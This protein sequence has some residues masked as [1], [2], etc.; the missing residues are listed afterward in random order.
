MEKLLRRKTSISIREII[1]LLL[2]L[3]ALIS[4]FVCFIGNQDYYELLPLLPFTFII[5]QLFFGVPSKQFFTTKIINL[6]AYLRYVVLP[7]VYS[8]TPVYGYSSYSCYDSAEI[9]SA[10]LFMCYELLFIAVFVALYQKRHLPHCQERITVTNNPVSENGKNGFAG[11]ILFIIFAAGIVL[12]FPGAFDQISF[13]FLKSNTG[14]R[15]GDL[16]LSASSVQMIFR[17]VVI[18]AI[19]S[20][21]VVIVSKIKYRFTNKNSLLP[22]VLSLILA[23]LCTCVII[24]EQR[25]SQVYCAFAAIVLL[26]K[27]YPDKRKL[28]I[29]VMVFVGVSVILFLTLYKTLYVFKFTSYGEAIAQSDSYFSLQYFAK[30]L[31]IYLL[32]PQTV[33]SSF[34]FLHTIS[35]TSMVQFLYDLA[36]P[37]I[38]L[39]FFV[40]DGGMQLTSELFNLYVTRAITSGYLLPISCHASLFIGKI[41]A[42]T[43]ICIIYWVA[44]R[45]EKLMFSSKSQYVV[46]FSAY[47]YIRLSSCMVCANLATVLNCISSVLISAGLVYLFQ[48]CFDVIL[49]QGQCHVNSYQKYN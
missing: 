19:L 41:L 20:L 23:A 38:G 6:C 34:D 28:I 8:F 40:K 2:L 11:I 31:E 48:K 36:R 43:L 17:Q 22:L 42:P 45:I 15:V 26:S 47:V 10:I 44:Y 27:L 33:A 30:N 35:S 16:S 25:S 13:L 32:G 37:F 1:Q 7:F 29:R 9:G 4:V 18:I 49:K 21:F 14:M 24:S 5:C 46:F 12:L 39:S 3:F